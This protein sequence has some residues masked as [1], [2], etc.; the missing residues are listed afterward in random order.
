MFFIIQLDVF[1]FFFV[2]CSPVSSHGSLNSISFSVRICIRDSCNTI[3]LMHPFGFELAPQGFYKLHT[4]A[5]SG[6]AASRLQLDQVPTRWCCYGR[7]RE[8]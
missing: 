8:S 5:I 3:C 6:Q 2:F 4:V 1:V 7:S